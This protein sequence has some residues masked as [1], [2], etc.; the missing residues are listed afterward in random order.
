MKETTGTDFE[1]TKE[2]FD[3]TVKKFASKKKGSYDFIVKSSD[4]YKDT[5]FKLTKRMIAE[6]TFPSRFFDT[7]LCQLW[8]RKG[9]VYDLN[10]HRYIHLKD[11]MP[12]LC[13]AIAVDQMK[14]E[15]ISGGTMYQ[16][17]GIPG[18]RREEHLVVVKSLIQRNL[19]S[20]TGCIGQLADFEK[21]FRL[22]KS[23][24]AYGKPRRVWC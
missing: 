2:I 3:D 20:K 15:I 12:K 22:R 1:V 7:T 21:F 13:E 16:I 18:H 9:S 23:E 17:G 4:E 8:K 6:E 11:W 19:T 24:R 10:N 14:E 5:I